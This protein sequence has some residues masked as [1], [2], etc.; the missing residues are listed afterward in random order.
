MTQPVKPSTT[1]LTPEER[2]S[3][4]SAADAVRCFRL[5]VFAGQRLNHLLD[6]RLRKAGL[7]TQQGVLLTIVR[8]LGRP[9]LGEVAL[10]MS[11]THQNAKQIAAALERKGMLDIVPDKTDGRVKRLVATAAGKRGWQ[12]RNAGDFAAIDE[13]FSALTRQEQGQ[14]AKLLAMLVEPLSSRS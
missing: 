13:W 2:V 7:T 14:L 1:R 12:D 4:G 9:T 8:S 6:Q 10:A 11:T 3:A 5:I